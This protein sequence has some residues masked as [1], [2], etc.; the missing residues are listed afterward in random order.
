M[1]CTVCQGELDTR[2]VVVTVVSNGATYTATLHSSCMYQVV[3]T[4]KGKKLEAI[5]FNSGWIQ[6]GLP[7]LYD[8]R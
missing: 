3:G 8:K 7:L 2:G 4:E 1:K 6:T 5:A